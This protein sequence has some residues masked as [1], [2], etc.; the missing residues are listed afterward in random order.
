MTLGA[1]AW[2]S[3]N[4]VKYVLV[5]KAIGRGKRNGEREYQTLKIVFS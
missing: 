2:S 3:T 4:K 1:G 5:E